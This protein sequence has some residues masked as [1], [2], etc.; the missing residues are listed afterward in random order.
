[1]RRQVCRQV[2]R[3]ECRKVG[4]RVACPCCAVRSVAR[5]SA[6]RAAKRRARCSASAASLLTGLPSATRSH[7]EIF[8]RISRRGHRKQLLKALILVLNAVLGCC[9]VSTISETEVDFSVC[10]HTAASYNQGLHQQVFV[11][12]L[13]QDD[14]DRTER[15]VLEAITLSNKQ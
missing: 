14:T 15:H 12:I 7:L 5:S 2:R 6:Q 11:K 3:A 1:M 4:R 9:T 10:H 8:D 13:R